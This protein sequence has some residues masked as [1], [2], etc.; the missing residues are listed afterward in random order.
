[1]KNILLNQRALF[2]LAS[3]VVILTGC[4]S[5]PSSKFHQLS[6]LQNKTSVAHDVSP[7]QSQVIAIG[8]V[9]MPDYLDR[10]QIVTR[11]GKNELK[12]SEFD[13]WAGSLG[14][15]VN[16][17]LVEDISGLLPAERF[18]VMIWTP[19][20]ESQVPASYRV[21]VLVD[22][23][24]GTLGDAVL[25]RAQWAVF[26]KDRILLLNKESE[27]SKKING[28]SY[29]ALVTAMSDALERLS[30]DISGGILSILQKEPTR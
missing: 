29:D 28:I 18:S 1:M 21:E 19:Y 17:V 5:S 26:A 25:L 16:R 7:D 9:R 12:L 22:R 11:S 4:A 15:D 6:P 8:P 27:I 2:T 10:P 23:F 20:L 14:D 24:D 13:R 30:S 3:L